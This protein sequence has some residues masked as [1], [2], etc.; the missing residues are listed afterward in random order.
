MSLMSDFKAFIFKGNVIDLAVGVIIGS[1]F[2]AIVTSLVENI[3]TPLL[4]NPA[5]KAAHLDD[6]KGLSYGGIK[7][8]LFLS[9]VITFL[10]IAFV[11]FLLVQAAHKA[12]HK[13]A[14]EP[15][16]PPAPTAT[17]KLLMEIR[18]ELKKP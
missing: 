18:D 12:M 2:G 17:E 7:Y 6:I 10:V 8:G 3:I 1:A 5:L 9:A 15:A 13:K 16:A 11:L 14:Q 4:L